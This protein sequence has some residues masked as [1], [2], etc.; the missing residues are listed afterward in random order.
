MQTKITYYQ[1]PTVFERQLYLYNLYHYI[2]FL[3]LLKHTSKVVITRIVL[4]RRL[5]EKLLLASCNFE[6]ATDMS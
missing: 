3:G 6:G 5:Y 1:T 4:L 2:Y